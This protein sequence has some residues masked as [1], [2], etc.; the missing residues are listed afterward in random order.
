M[1]LV[2]PFLISNDTNINLNKYILNLCYKPP[3]SRAETHSIKIFFWEGDTSP[4]SIIISAKTL[5]KLSAFGTTA[6]FCKRVK[7]L[8]KLATESRKYYIKRNTGKT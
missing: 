1:V 3:K 5:T 8:D 7:M 2:K 4:R 6:W